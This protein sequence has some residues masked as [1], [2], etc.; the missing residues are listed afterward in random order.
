MEYSIDYGRRKNVYILIRDGKVILKVPKNYPKYK[1]EKI[2]NEKEK[3]INKKLQEYNQKNRNIR[4]YKDGA[5]I[6]VLGNRYILKIE[7]YS[8]T[9]IMVKLEDSNF[10]IYFPENLQINEEL[11]KEVIEKY[12]CKLAKIELPKYLE[13]IAKEVNLYPS[14]CSVR[15]MKRAWG[16][17]NTK[18]DIH[19]N[20]N[21]I[22]YSK[23]AIE[24]V[25]LHE[26]CHLKYMNH[27]KVFWEMV[28]SY[29]PNYKEIE[30]ELR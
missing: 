15:N 20:T 2:I 6:Y 5:N 8:K 21:L 9:R 18:K 26:I 4:E 12:Y 3:W 11:I 27:S 14:S 30:K 23:Q 13:N 10:V 1:M 24:Y 16:N 7:Y 22:K 28:E 19:L 25:C 29:M 17:C